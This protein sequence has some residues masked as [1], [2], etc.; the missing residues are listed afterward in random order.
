MHATSRQAQTPEKHI[1]DILQGTVNHGH[2]NTVR[3]NDV[4]NMAKS[5]EK[6]IIK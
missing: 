3:A 4:K 5:F 2:N 6:Y 1:Q